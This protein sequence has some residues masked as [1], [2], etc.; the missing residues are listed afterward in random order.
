[1]KIKL[2]DQVEWFKDELDLPE[3]NK[4]LQFYV[5]YGGEFNLNKGFSPNKVLQFYVR[6]G[7]EFQLK[8]GFSPAFRVE[9]REDVEIGY[10]EN[11][12]DLILVVS[13]EDLWYFE[14]NEVLVEK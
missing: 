9:P 4:V 6:Y 7:G 11:Y 13:E 12:N 10:E 5:R 14:D 3:N 1:M 8:Q 2:T